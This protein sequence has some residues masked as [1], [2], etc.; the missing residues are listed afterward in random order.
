LNAIQALIIR[1]QRSNLHSIPTDCPHREKRGW[2]AD[3]GVTAPEAAFNFNM[4]SFYE[5]WLRTHA[6]T[7]D[8]GCGPLEKNWTCPKWNKNQ[9]GAGGGG[10]TMGVAATGLASFS[11]GGCGAAFSP[12][13]GGGGGGVDSVLI[14]G[15]SVKCRP[16]GESINQWRFFHP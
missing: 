8:V 14:V 12:S 4:A 16:E 3:A 2:M 1:T 15:T 11:F 9:P 13:G 6:D 10:G 5:N 7:S